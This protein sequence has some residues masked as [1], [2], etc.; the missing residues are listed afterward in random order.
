MKEYNFKDS[1][2]KFRPYWEQMNLYDTGTDPAKPKFYCLDFFPYPSG[3]GLS[4]GH[5]RN[6]IPSDVIS[7]KIRMDGFN[8]L[9]P[10]G[11]DSFGQPAEE[12]A[13]KVGKHP[14]IT[15]NEA[16]Q[17]YKK[18]MKLIEASYDWDRELYSCDP[19]YYKWT[20]YLFLLLFK[21]GLAYQ[22][23]SY[24]W[25]C[26]F[27]KIV[28]S[29]EQA[30][31]GCCWRC[32]KEVTK[33]RL[34]QWF[35]RITNYAD[36][37]LEGLERIDWPESIK[38]MQKNWIGRSE[39]TK[40]IFKVQNEKGV[41]FELPVFTTRIDTIFGATFCV[42]APEH[43]L[44]KDLT[45]SDRSF[46]VEQ[47][48]QDSLKKSNLQRISI[49]DK[50]K[51]GVFIGSYAINPFSGEKVPVFI[52][53]YV[54]MEY[55]TG[56]IMAVPAHDSRDFEF[57]RRYNLPVKEVISPTGRPLK[58]GLNEAYT[59]DGIMVNSEQF[60][61][62]R[63]GEAIDLMNKYALTEGFGK[64]TINYKFHDWL[65]SRQRYWGAPIPIIH[66]NECGPLPVP[67]EDLPVILPQVESFGPDESGTSP[68]AKVPSFINTK[69]PCCNAPAK[70]DPDTIDGFAC[71]S[72]YFLRFASPHHKDAA[73]DDTSVKY[74]LPVDLYLG[75]AEH[76]VMHLLYA[77]FWTKVMYD[78]GMI[79]FDEPFKK[80]K[81]QGMLLGSDGQKMSKSKGNVVTPDEMIKKYGTDALRT[82]ILFMG[83]FEAEIAWSED[84]IAGCSRF[85]RRVWKL[86]R[87]SINI[88][89]LKRPETL[90]EKIKE[91]EYMT[92]YTIKKVSGDIDNLHF[93]TAVAAIMEFTNYL[94]QQIHE[95]G[96]FGILWKEALESLIRVLSPIA[97][98]ITEEL[99]KVL[100]HADSIH[101]QNW[102]TWSDKKLKKDIITIAIQVNGKLRDSIQIA[103]DLPG[104]EVEQKAFENEKI[105]KHIKD[106]NIIK[107][108]YVKN[109]I[110]NI[111]VK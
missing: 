57:A 108:I 43:P 92:H 1:E 51:T 55:G 102:L 40:L 86:F 111:V 46:E 65:I 70:R 60:N 44:I 31:N 95:A 12:Y 90:D 30:S 48:I 85:L 71:S 105:K 49:T 27:C 78:A 14:Q 47:Y 91:I 29:N 18:Q 79:N 75:G 42:L 21:R 89:T 38:L 82:Y 22:D 58:E 4:L 104:K 28:L 72:W 53:D 9:H 36:R 77:R 107:T 81:N 25:Y 33:V 106:K 76:A 20:Q 37:L 7:R 66:C 17:T 73:F 16:A 2:R 54:L 87:D 8:V 110:L 24:Q 67:E 10:M 99:W 68:L 3:S 19:D 63:S 74:W 62:L 98:F 80:L 88:M 45:T 13:L 50:D 32:E 64:P 96:R 26:P 109:K 84:G 5:C 69:C 61:G 103:L 11:W 15:I 101:K 59:Q 41:L 97:P 52:A 93:N 6:Y 34:R 56:A 23:Y 35:F 83:P 100:G 94:S 39:G